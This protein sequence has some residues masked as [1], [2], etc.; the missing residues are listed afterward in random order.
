MYDIMTNV[1]TIRIVFIAAVHINILKIKQT[2]DPVLFCS[3]C[4]CI[5]VPDVWSKIW[6]LIKTIVSLQWY[7]CYCLEGAQSRSVPTPHPPV[8]HHHVSYPPLYPHH[9]V[10]YP[11]LVITCPG[12]GFT[13]L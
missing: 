10:S 6:A 8:P 4:S 3:P 7:L 2:I 1:I 13:T 5:S 12:P 11:P 9:H